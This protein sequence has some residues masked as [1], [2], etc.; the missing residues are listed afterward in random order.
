MPILHSPGVMMPGQLGPMRRVPRAGERGLHAHHVVD[1]NA[2]GDAHHELDAGIGRL[3]DRV[4]RERRR[5]VDDAGGGAGFF[6]RIRHGVEHRQ[7]QVLLAAAA[8][9]DAADHL[10]A[11]LDA[12]LGVERALLAGE[13]L[14]DDAWCSC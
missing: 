4:G 13:A 6:D 2:L 5:H 9:R 12:L 14:A 7:V 10:R 3:E 1:R 8:G 11:V